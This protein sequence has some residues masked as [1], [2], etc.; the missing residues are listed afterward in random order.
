MLYRKKISGNQKETIKKEVVPQKDFAF[1][2][3]ETIIKDIVQ[4]KHFAFN[5]K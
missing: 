5:E 4:H 1:I 2:E 3:K